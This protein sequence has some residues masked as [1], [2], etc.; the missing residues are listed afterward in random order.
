MH[1]HGFAGLG[2]PP[3]LILLMVALIL[4]GPWGVFGPRGPFPK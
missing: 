4:F 1:S 2:L 3:L